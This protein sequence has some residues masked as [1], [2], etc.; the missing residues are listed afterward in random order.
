MTNNNEIVQ[1]QNDEFRGRI[2]LPVFGKP[3]IK[4]NHLYTR[5]II[6]LGAE[7]QIIIAAKVRDFDS[8]S[9]DNDPHGEHDF[10]SLNYEGQ[11]IFWKIDCYDTEYQYGSADP[12]DPTKTRRVLTVML[13]SEY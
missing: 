7:A 12:A 6:A 5:G 4:G 1:K 9:E 8:F 2:M 10:G 11:K 13:A 3:A